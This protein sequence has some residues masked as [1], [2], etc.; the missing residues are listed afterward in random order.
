VFTRNSTATFFFLLLCVFAECMYVLRYYLLLLIHASTLTSNDSFPG[1]IEN[2]DCGKHT[3]SRSG[4]PRSDR[5][6]VANLT[7]IPN[8]KMY[9]QSEP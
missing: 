7:G 3:Q 8:N 2:H 6:I 5:K 1:E 4:E 9:S